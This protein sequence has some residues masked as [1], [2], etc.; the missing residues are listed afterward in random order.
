MKFSIYQ[1]IKSI[2]SHISFNFKYSEKIEK[3]ALI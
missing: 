2:Y 1:F 3:I